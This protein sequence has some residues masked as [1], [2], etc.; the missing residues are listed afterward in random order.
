MSTPATDPSTVTMEPFRI[1]VPESEV[2]D[3]RRRLRAARWPDQV[4]GSGWTYGA[5]LSA[6]RALAEY[7]ADGYD[8]R[9]HEAELNETPQLMAR[10]DG[11]RFHV[12][13]A[14]SR[15]PHAL[16]L[17][18]THGW[19]GSIAE[20]RHMIGP[21]VDPVAHGGDAAD[22]F[23]VVAPSLPGYGFS[24]PTTEPGW[25]IERAAHAFARIMAA[26]GYR[27]YAAQGGDWG[28]ML[29]RHLGR[30]DAEHVV[31]VHVNVMIGFPSGR[32]DDHADVTELERALLARMDD[33]MANGSGYVAIQST[34]PQTLAYS[35]SDSPVGLLAWIADKFWAWTDHD[36]D[37]LTAVSRDDLLTNVSIYWFTGTGGSS[38]RMYYES[39]RS[40]S[41]MPPPFRDVPLGVA[42]FPKELL[43]AR[44]RWLEADYDIA[45]WTELDRGGHFAALE[46]PDL[47]VDDVRAFFRPLR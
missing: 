38:A 40:G 20:F 41:V 28:S 24:G 12:L 44:R 13:H 9:R 10:V 11:Q 36:G 42:V 43:Y 15:E 18:I 27:R 31:G 39:L 22:A 19:P 35:L 25:D 34:R 33:Y 46:E 8:W 16:P 26:L 1:A 7:W 17:V 2:D 4:P 45:R 30:L 47:L 5:D 29:A 37:F 14:R 21:L 32:E 23:H 3:L 6:M